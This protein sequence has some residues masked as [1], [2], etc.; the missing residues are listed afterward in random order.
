VSSAN[1]E[2]LQM[3]L[4]FDCI[5]RLQSGLCSTTARLT[6]AWRF[7]ILQGCFRATNLKG[8]LYPGEQI[9][10]HRD[11]HP[12][13]AA[14]SCKLS[15]GDRYRDFRRPTMS[16]SRSIPIIGQAPTLE[17]CLSASS[18]DM[19]LLRTRTSHAHAHATELQDLVLL[20]S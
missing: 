6:V 20:Q 8:S 3:L 13:R 18:I 10:V 14:T 5:Y 11:S 1:R 12:A 9:S 2:T 15:K 19:R 16:H 17:P 4:E 7:T